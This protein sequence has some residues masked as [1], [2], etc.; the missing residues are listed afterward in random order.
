MRWMFIL[1]L[2]LL[3]S[4]VGAEQTAASF[5]IGGPGS[6]GS[7]GSSDPGTLSNGTEASASATIELDDQN[8]VLVLT[9]QNTSPVAAGVCNP[10]LTEFFFNVPLAVTGA[11]LDSQVPFEGPVPTFDLTFDPDRTSNPNPN[12]AGSFGVFSVGLTLQGIQ[13]GIVNPAADTYPA[14]MGHLTRGPV[15]F[16]F[17]L[18]G[19]LEGL[20]ADD[21]ANQYSG[22]PPGNHPS[23]SA[24]KFQG[25]GQSCDESGFINDVSEECMAIVGLSQGPGLFPS[26][27]IT[28]NTFPT[29][30]SNIRL[31]QG[32]NL[33]TPL[34]LRLPDP[35]PATRRMLGVDGTSQGAVAGTRMFVQ[36]VM[37]NPGQ[38]PANPEQTSN[39]IELSIFSDGTF[40]ATPYGLADGM[41]LQA[42][43]VTFSDGRRYARMSFTIE[44]I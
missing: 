10:V 41:S 43:T 40:T 15:V 44:G 33:N 1:A 3:A 31:Y 22:T 38:F 4:D 12:G 9:L 27:M 17:S 32:V 8:G 18:E 28:G 19:D 26:P 24:A 25:G 35:A 14:P 5:T 6:F 2:G 13:D 11:T 42:D 16:T 29:Q 20:T 30:L 21:F 39:G 37:W 23:A 7:N 34:M 36:I